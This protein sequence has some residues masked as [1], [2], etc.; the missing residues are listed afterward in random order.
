M[1]RRLK[2]AG[3]TFRLLLGGVHFAVAKSCRGNGL[4]IA[5]KSPTLWAMNGVS[6]VSALDGVTLGSWRE[7]ERQA[8][9]G[10]SCA[11]S[12][13]LKKNSPK[14]IM[15]IRALTILRHGLHGP[16]KSELA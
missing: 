5:Q 2:A 4:S 1:K 6:R 14:L 15:P 11:R 7:A 9:K 13:G 3:V 8:A 16:L 12:S 10:H